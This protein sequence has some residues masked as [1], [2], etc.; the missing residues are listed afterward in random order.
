[1]PSSFSEVKSYTW[2]L[3]ASYS[4]NIG[5]F[6]FNL[7]SLKA[8]IDYKLVK[9]T[10]DGRGFY[11]HTITEAS[12]PYINFSSKG[13]FFDLKGKD[14]TTVVSYGYTN[15]LAQE[16]ETERNS[17]E[18]DDLE[19][20]EGSDISLYKGP[21]ITT[22]KST[23]V[24]G[25]S[26]KSGYTF[27]QSFDNRYL[28][29]FIQDNYYTKINGSVYVS[30]NAPD[31][32]FSVT[33]TVKPSFN[34]ANN[35]MSKLSCNQ[36]NDFKLNSELLAS[37]PK[38]GLTYKLNTKVYSY[39][40]KQT[41]SSF[42]SKQGFGEWKK[43]DVTAHSLTYSQ[44]VGLFTF[45][46]ALQFKPLTE[47]IKPL[48]S[49]KYKGFSA[50]ADF[51]MEKKALIYEKGIANLNASYSNSY[52]S[53]SIANR[54]DFLKSQHLK[55]TQKASIKPFSGLT[56]M[57][58]AVLLDRFALE[59]FNIRALYACDTASFKL[60]SDVSMS[61]KDKT[62]NKES[63]SV[64]LALSTQKISL[65]KN[66]IGIQTKANLKFDYHFD[67][68]YRS[69]FSFDFAFD[70]AV[71]EFVDLSFKVSSS[72]KNFSKY[73]DGDVFVLSKMLDDLAKSFDFFGDGRRSTGFNMNS[74]SLQMIHYMKD[75]NLCID[76]SG[77]L[78][79]KYSSKYEWVPQVTV[80]VKWN[81]LPEL[82]TEGNWDASNKEWH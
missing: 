58:D 39:Y 26:L 34:F 16:L 20:L 70:F 82:K 65:W 68:P 9:D 10:K 17:L 7:S 49:F 1:F 36:V 57:Q 74:I 53:F 73:Y 64:K 2:A 30:A 13:T 37:I 52:L 54:Y 45:G 50:N 11:Q 27:N 21:N 19:E 29:N 40:S 66:R 42:D 22:E 81:A 15:V 78:T 59:S 80:Y 62:F 61:F 67:N 41:S 12:L 55:I 25:S 5:A 71:A 35:D 3:D 32:W 75:W 47:N 51:T 48:V 56:L 28:E 18:F 6:S 31:S 33:E 4:K 14:S 23:T 77:N 46:L 60:D 72:N 79:T 38:I 43:E 69:L 8:D 76:V 44:N 63:L 24:K